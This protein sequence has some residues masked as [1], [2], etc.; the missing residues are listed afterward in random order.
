MLLSAQAAIARLQTGWLKGQVIPSSSGGWKFKIKALAGLVSVRPL[1]LACRRPPSDCV[2]YGFLPWVWKQGHL[3]VSLPLLMRKQS[4]WMRDPPFWAHLTFS[5]SLKAL[6]P[7]IVILGIRA[8][9]YKIWGNII[10]LKMYTLS[11]NMVNMWRNESET[12]KSHMEI[13]MC[14]IISVSKWAFQSISL[15]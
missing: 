15:K 5:Y 6:Y 7:N 11:K 1:F 12:G 8:S 4:C 2:P 14:I 9:T 3:L 10:Q 13:M